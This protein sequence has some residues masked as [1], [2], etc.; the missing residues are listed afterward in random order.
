MKTERGVCMSLRVRLSGILKYILLTAVAIVMFFPV[1]WIA[2]SSLK[3]LIGISAYPPELIPK[4]LHFENYVEVFTRPQSNI[5]YYLKNTLI[6]IIGNTVGT[7]IS[8]SIVAFPLARMKFSGQKIVFGLILATMM[9]PSTALVVPQYIMFSKFGWLNS[10]LPIIVP[11]F[12]AYP[13]NVFL[14]RQFY[15]TIP[16]SIDES[17]LI[18][19]CNRWGIFTRMIVPL[20]RPI[21]ISVGVLSSVFWWNELFVPLIYL[22]SDVLKPLTTGALTA[23]KNLFISMWNIQMAMSMLMIIPPMI[24]YL[25][26]SKY[27]AEGIKTSGTK[28]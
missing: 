6:L 12:F 27:L 17:A 3:S 10:F 7:L 13:Y 19:G 5:L 4:E 28:G 20:S 2:S 15:R 25:F 14:F 16:A 9:V 24:L 18:D 22:D 21:F 11:A 1:L 26:A 23:F 8:S